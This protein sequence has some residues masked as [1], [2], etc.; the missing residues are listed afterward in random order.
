MIFGDKL[1]SV[2]DESS[3][4]LR[5]EKSSINQT[6]EPFSGLSALHFLRNRLMP[7]GRVG[8]EC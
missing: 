4:S 7:S 5:T 1:L 6:F 8:E 2:D 3:K